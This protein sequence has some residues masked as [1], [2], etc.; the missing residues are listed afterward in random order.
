MR[1]IYKMSRKASFLVWHD[2]EPTD[3]RVFNTIGGDI[4]TCAYSH[5]QARYQIIKR[6]ARYM[7]VSPRDIEID[8]CDILLERYL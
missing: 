8:N 2:E 6:L 7:H 3:Y 1:A 4:Y 5:K